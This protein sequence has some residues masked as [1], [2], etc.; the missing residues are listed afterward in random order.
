MAICRNEYA[1]SREK[2][3]KKNDLWGQNSLLTLWPMHKAPQLSIEEFM[4]QKKLGMPLVDVRSPLEYEKGHI[5]GA[6]NIPLFD[7]HERHEIGTIY[8][9]KGKEE[10]VMRGLEIVSPK[11]AEFV[12]QVKANTPGGKVLIYCF[13][14]GMRSNSFGWLMN[15]AGLDAKILQGGY[16]NY[17]NYVISIFEKK[18]KIVLL[19]GPTGGGKTEVLHHL[20]QKGQQVIDLEGIAHHKGSAFG[21]I[22]MPEQPSQQNFEN[23][24]AEAFESID[25]EQVLWLED[26]SFMIGSC[27]TPFTLWTRMKQSPI[28]SLQVPFE[29]RIIRL[30][31]DYGNTS[32]ESLRK[33][34]M[35]IRQK[36][37]GQHLNEALA[38]LE[39]G[40]L[41][42]VAAMALGYYD[43][44]YRY[45]H[46]KRGFKG[47]YELV[48]DTEDAQYNAN[49]VLNYYQSNH[50]QWTKGSD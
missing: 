7:N 16:K 22:N 42:K 48:S 47:V 33:G 32:V 38:F 27:R 9:Q 45:N 12:K 29:K 31:Q 11:L 15:T 36:L 5:P 23:R 44:A 20:K 37:G 24:L 3:V 25:S 17:R 43:E 10:A 14:G 21:F 34:L 8:K 28:I 19:G 13:R 39:N 2:L 46:E 40:E 49:L 35:G 26:E 50:Q 30:V 4:A 41:D 6:I 18:Y 1:F